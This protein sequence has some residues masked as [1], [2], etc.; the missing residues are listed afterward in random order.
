[1][2]EKKSQLTARRVLKLNEV[3]FDWS[4]GGTQGIQRDLAW[5]RQLNE[6]KKWKEENNHCNVP[7]NTTLGKWVASQRIQYRALLRGE[8]SAMTD[9]R[10]NEL[11]DIGLLD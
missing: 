3:G 1:M 11:D 8:K 10:R 9:K 2:R 7:R 4:R 5:H 6:L